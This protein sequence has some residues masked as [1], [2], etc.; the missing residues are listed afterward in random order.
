MDGLMGVQ[1]LLYGVRSEEK[2]VRVR[3]A[4]GRSRWERVS[5]WMRG[6]VPSLNGK[7]KVV[8]LE[9]SQRLIQQSREWDRTSS[10][11]GSII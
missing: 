6:W 10:R 1:F 3:D 9:E 8:G 7:E 4:T 2:I 5:G 11:Y